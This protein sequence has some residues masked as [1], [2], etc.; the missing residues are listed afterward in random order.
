MRPRL[1]IP[2]VAFAAPRA[3][4]LSHVFRRDFSHP[5]TSGRLEGGMKFRLLLGALAF[6]LT[7]VI[8]IA[9]SAVISGRITAEDQRALSDVTVS[10]PELGLGTVTRDDGRFTINVP[11]AR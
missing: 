6:G 10:I 2:P 8:A 11:G 7:P 4:A 3:V 1:L 9:Q 5:F